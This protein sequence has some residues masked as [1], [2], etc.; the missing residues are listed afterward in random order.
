MKKNSER[1]LSIS[2]IRK[3]LA[4]VMVI[5][6]ALL[7]FVPILS[8]TTDDKTPGSDPFV[9]GNAAIGGGPN[10]DPGP[11]VPQ[12]EPPALLPIKVV[13]D[14]NDVEGR[15]AGTENGPFNLLAYEADKNA[16]LD[17]APQGNAPTGGGLNE[18][19]S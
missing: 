5:C 4:S 14:S 9:Q 8:S 6:L 16:S 17:P 7:V 19:L 1:T 2:A 12:P 15:G 3:I 10:A 13:Q 11:G 18:D